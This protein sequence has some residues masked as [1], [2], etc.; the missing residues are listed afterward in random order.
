[1]SENALSR[2][3]VLHDRILTLDCD[4]DTAESEGRDITGMLQERVQLVNECLAC[5][6]RVRHNERYLQHSN[7]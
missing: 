1:M 6:E 3:L 4:I 2:A 7:L 5:L